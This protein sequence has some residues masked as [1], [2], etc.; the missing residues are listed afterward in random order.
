MFPVER[1]NLTGSMTRF[2]GVDR[3]LPNLP[4]P[5][6]NEL[7]WPCT[8]CRGSAASP[9]N[10]LAICLCTDVPLADAACEGSAETRKSL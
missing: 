9:V 3:P 4:R 2:V 8:T 6:K 7:L 10:T 5:N 1:T